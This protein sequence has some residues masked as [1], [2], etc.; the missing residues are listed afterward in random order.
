MTLKKLDD[1][2]TVFK[3]KLSLK[4]KILNITISYR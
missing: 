1:F 2:D 3:N 4:T